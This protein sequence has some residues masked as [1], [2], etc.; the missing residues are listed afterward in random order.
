MLLE[1]R[2]VRDFTTALPLP[3][4]SYS[5]SLYVIHKDAI[6]ATSYL[7][8]ERFYPKTVHNCS[9]EKRR[10]IDKSLQLQKEGGGSDVDP[11]TLA[12]L[13]QQ[14][15]NA[16]MLG[17]AVDRLLKGSMSGKKAAEI[18][19]ILEAVGGDDDV[20]TG[21]NP[22]RMAFVATIGNTGAVGLVIMDRSTLS[23]DRISFFKVSQRQ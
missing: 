11:E 18:R 19:G 1:P 15:Q 5:Q 13:N 12:A 10:Q 4:T 2:I 20:T 23:A 14:N 8:V 9:D 16:F 21:D 3:G 7:R 22:Q 6:L 17:K